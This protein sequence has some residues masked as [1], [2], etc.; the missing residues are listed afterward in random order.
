MNF[1]IPNYNP[2]KPIQFTL[3][4]YQDEQQVGDFSLSMN[5]YVS[6]FKEGKGFTAE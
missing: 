2:N 6:S 1:S 5:D 4:L 3:T